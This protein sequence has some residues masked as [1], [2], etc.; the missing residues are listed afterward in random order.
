LW[1][2]LLQIVPDL[3]TGQSI[4]IPRLQVQR[5]VHRFAI[6]MIN[7]INGQSQKES[8]KINQPFKPYHNSGIPKGSKLINSIWLRKSLFQLLSREAFT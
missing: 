5:Q 8:G 6:A 2:L 4:L 1:E 3:G 7:G